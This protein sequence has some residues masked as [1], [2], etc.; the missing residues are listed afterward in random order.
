MIAHRSL[1]PKA[2]YPVLLGLLLGQGVVLGR[3][4]TSNWRTP[5]GHEDWWTYVSSVY[6]LRD[7]QG[8]LIYDIPSLTAVQAAL[9]RSEAVIYPYHPAYLLLVYPFAVLPPNMSYVGWMAFNIVLLAFCLQMLA[10]RFVPTNERRLFFLIVGASLPVYI[11]LAYGQSSFV[12]LLGVSLVVVGT[13]SGHDIRSGLGLAVLLIK[14]QYLLLWLALLLWRRQLRALAFFSVAG[15]ILLGLSYLLVGSDGLF[16]YVHLLASGAMAKRYAASYTLNGIAYAL[17]GEAS[18]AVTYALMSAVVLAGYVFTL[19]KTSRHTEQRSLM[20]ITLL[21]SMLVANY[22]L[23]YD[24][25][26]WSVVLALLWSSATV[27]NARF[28]LA[29]GFTAPW[30]SFACAQL[31]FPFVWPTVAV[32]VAVLVLLFRDAWRTYSLMNWPASIS[33]G[34]CNQET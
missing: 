11:A 1:T 26:M 31:G 20:A 22:L 19:V 5:F 25:T 27:G 33:G 34:E 15:G 17:P 23:I 30:I 8:H 2:I 10:S 32:A 12:V 4:V 29:A 6:M 16:S 3:Y 13:I 21:A 18:T 28:L 9:G 7:G 14:P 24:L